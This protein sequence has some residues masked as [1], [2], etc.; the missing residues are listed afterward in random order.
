MS[1]SEDVQKRTFTNWANNY[2]NDR[3]YEIKD[4]FTDLDDGLML[5]NLLEIISSKKLGRYN[6]KPSLKFQ[7]GE[8]LTLCFSFLASENI[9]LV[10]INNEDIW[11]HNPRLILG[12]LW[13][14]ILRYQVNRVSATAEGPAATSAKNAIL[15]WVSSRSREDVKSFSDFNDGRILS[16]LVNHLSRLA[17]QERPFDVDALDT[18]DGFGNN[19][20]AIKKAEEAPLGIRALIDADVL[21]TPKPDDMS[22]MTYI[23][24]YIAKE[25]ELLGGRPWNPE[26]SLDLQYTVSGPGVSSPVDEQADTYVLILIKDSDGNVVTSAPEEQPASPGATTEGEGSPEVPADDGLTPVAAPV[27]AASVQVE[28]FNPEGDQLSVAPLQTQEDGHLRADYATGDQGGYVITIKDSKGSHV[29]DSPYEVTVGPLPDAANSKAYGPGLVSPPVA[30]ETHFFV[31]ARNTKGDLIAAPPAG[32]L[33]KSK[34]PVTVTVTA[35]ETGAV[36]PS[37][38]DVNEESIRN[39][40][41]SPE[42]QGVHIVEVKVGGEHVVGSPFQVPVRNKASGAQSKAYGPGLEA[43]NTAGAEAQF[44]VEVC[45]EEGN[46]IPVTGV[47]TDEATGALAHDAASVVVTNPAGEAVAVVLTAN[48]DGTRGAAYTPSEKGTYGVAVVVDGEPVPGSEF[49]VAILGAPTGGSSSA[50]GVGLERPLAGQPAPFVVT[51]R[52]VD[53]DVIPLR[54]D[55]PADAELVKVAVRDAAG[56]EVPFTSTIAEDGTVQVEYLPPAAG[57]YEVD[58]LVGEE[59]VP[60]ST[61]SPEIRPDY[62]ASKCEAFGP[63]LESAADHV[64]TDF[65]V[66]VRDAAGNDVACL[67]LEEGVTESDTNPTGHVNVKITGPDGEEVPAQLTPAS[68]GT[69]KVSYEPTSVGDHQ[70]EV[71]VNGDGVPGSV[72]TVPVGSGADVSKTKVEGKG[73]KKADTENPTEFVV[74]PRTAS[75]DAR[76]AGADEITAT[77]TDADGEDIPATVTDNG[78]GTYTVAYQPTKPVN[79]EV[80][81]KVNGETVPKAPFKV[82]VNVGADANNCTGEG[83]GLNAPMVNEETHFFVIKRDK[84]NEVAA[85]DPE[86][87]NFTCEIVDPSGKAVEAALVIVGSE[88][89]A[90]TEETEEAEATEEE[91]AA[92]AAAEETEETEGDDSAAATEAADE[93]TGAYRVTYTPLVPGRHTIKLC[94][95]GKAIKRSPFRVNVRKAATVSMNVDGIK[96]NDVAVKIKEGTSTHIIHELPGGRFLKISFD[97][98]RPEDADPSD[99]EDEVAGEEEEEEQQQEEA[100]APAAAAGSADESAAAEEAAP[101]A[102]AP[103]DAAPAEAAAV[104]EEI[105]A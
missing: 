25:N 23:S 51:V 72:F 38:I 13:T 91:A 12:L 87:D 8:N 9:K 97:V 64:D 92:P 50:E 59:H 52:D 68:D 32:G 99:D 53:G 98:G 34:E 103:K 42:S 65:F 47:V 84:N 85:F 22:C 102:E 30:I 70:V 63:G 80:D 18:A 82:K 73:T 74:T 40:V 95:N 94:I 60:G 101:T 93:H 21:V 44:T 6:R 57:K 62:D 56:Q 90:A 26:D 37:S 61:F 79:H 76:P 49:T 45:D 10:N 78:D 11:D 15:Q 33:A 29:A 2:L 39:V 36:L 4:L 104:E 20:A 5:I 19:D 17:G 88:Q 58:V 66:R 28:V 27:S 75:K 86:T 24:A 83:M 67:P 81:V 69:M 3:G 31:E 48:E 16:K 55:R 96:I 41:F 46:A 35:P 43:G 1:H 71:L 89:P 105:A 77:V 54:A 7:M 14:I 100:A